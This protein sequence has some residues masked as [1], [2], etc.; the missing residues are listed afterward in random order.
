MIAVEPNRPAQLVAS[1]HAPWRAT[2]AECL[3]RWA[4][5]DRD[6]RAR[7]YLVLEGDEPGVRRTLNGGRI[8]ELA[9]RLRSSG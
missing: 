9:A 5:L 6:A 1:L 2:V 4:D 7:S 8:A 3:T